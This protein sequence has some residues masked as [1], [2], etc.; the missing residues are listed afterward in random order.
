MTV[1][2]NSN[3]KFL[4]RFLLIATGLIG[5][6]LWGLYDAT[7]TGPKKMKQ[8]KEYWVES[9]EASKKWVPRHTGEEWSQIAKENHWEI[10]E[11]KT[12]SGAFGYSLFNYAL[13]VTCIPLGLFSLFKYLQS[14]KTWIEQD[15]STFQTS[16]GVKFDIDQIKSIDKR[17]WA[18]KGIA[19]ISYTDAG[20]EKTYVLDDFK[21]LREPTDEILYN[22][23]QSLEDEQIVNGVR[24]RSPAEVA[25]DK[26][27]A[28]EAKR[29][30]ENLD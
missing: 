5:F 13:V 30:R 23:E 18:K 16:K 25:E 14:N 20:A 6:G 3:S 27:K 28:E 9:E 15:G 4:L 29:E 24:E 21:Y 12:P 17:K 19:K 1:R 8:A 7:F 26:R 11:P 22:I 10:G 2:A